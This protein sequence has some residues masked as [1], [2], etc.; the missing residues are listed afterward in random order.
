MGVS[1]FFSLVALIGVTALPA[2]AGFEFN[3][4]PRAVPPATQTVPDAASQ[5]SSLEN[6]GPL[7]PM[8][9]EPV[10]ESDIMGTPPLPVAAVAAPPKNSTENNN[11]TRVNGFGKDVPL[12]LAL[13][14]IIPPAYRVDFAAGVDQNMLVSW[15][16]NGRPW[17]DVVDQIL[18]TV[19]LTVG[20]S[21]N[22]ITIKTID[23][24]PVTAAVG[25][26][27][28]AAGST[29]RETLTLWAQKNNAY[30][31]WQS[32]YD[33]PVTNAFSFDGS[34]EGAIEALLTLYQS[35]KNPPKGK[36]YPNLPN[37]PV[38]LVVK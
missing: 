18:R 26:W 27:Q 10:A 5:P 32:P 25:A 3:P 17:A 28:A 21:G 37:G 34:F 11:T 22:V 24:A 14:Q 9:I 7:T 8:P 19:N 4:P 36:L 15:N 12:N 1:R 35:D 6:S 29:L 38:V 30:L 2:F 31:E 16:G 23:A 33:Y 20:L 13:G